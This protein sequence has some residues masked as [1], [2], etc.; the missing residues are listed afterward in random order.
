MKKFVYISMS[1]NDS[2]SVKTAFQ[3]A[4]FSIAVKNFWK[5]GIAFFWCS[6][7]YKSARSQRY[8][9]RDMAIYKVQILIPSYSGDKWFDMPERYDSKSARSVLK[10]YHA[11]KSHSY[12]LK[13]VI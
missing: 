13:K 10:K 7:A 8:S 4:D 1:S 6:Q 9:A 2:D 5:S 12:R 3:H 11:D